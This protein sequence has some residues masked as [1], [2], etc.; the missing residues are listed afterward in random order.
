MCPKMQKLID[1][2]REFDPERL[3]CDECCD[4]EDHNHFPLQILPTI[5]KQFGFI[6]TFFEESEKDF[7]KALD[8]LFKYTPSL[9]FL[10]EQSIKHKID[11][12]FHVIDYFSRLKEI[13]EKVQE[14]YNKIR[15]LANDFDVLAI[16]KLE[17][18]I[19]ALYAQFKL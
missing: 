18:E 16:L 11:V 9:H 1:E 8:C 13:R 7:T 15:V 4:P 2:G 12:D 19:K 10:K 5:D 14:Y 6:K 3:F 17:K